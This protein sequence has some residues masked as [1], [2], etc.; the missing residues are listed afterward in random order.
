MESIQ[1]RP[2]WLVKKENCDSSK[3]SE[4]EDS[5]SKKYHQ[6]LGRLRHEEEWGETR[7]KKKDAGSRTKN[8]NDVGHKG[9]ADEDNGGE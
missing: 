8:N 7:A 4:G 6:M 3:P 9:R 1:D 5:S 2:R